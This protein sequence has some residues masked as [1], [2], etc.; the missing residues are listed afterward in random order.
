MKPTFAREEMN[1]RHRTIKLAKK[2]RQAGSVSSDKEDL[3]RA[4]FILK[5]L[6]FSYRRLA[7]V[8]RIKHHDT[9]QIY[10]YQAKALVEQKKLEICKKSNLVKGMFA[11][12]PAKLDYL[13]SDDNYFDHPSHNASSTETDSYEKRVVFF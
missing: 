2:K 9:C 6:G 10:Y 12:D 1:K 8:L 4:V 7:K 5:T 13:P 11:C 3:Y